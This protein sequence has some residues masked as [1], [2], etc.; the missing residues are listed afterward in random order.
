MVSW[1]WCF[2]LNLPIGGLVAILLF[3]I[4]IPEQMIKP[5]IEKAARTIIHELDLIGFALFSPAAIQ[6][7][8]A[9]SYGSNG[10]YAWNSATVIGLFGGAAGTFAVFLLWEHH[11]GAKA[12][13]PLNMIVNRK[14]WA[15]CLVM[16]GIYGTVNCTSYYLPI[17][18]QS[19]HNYSP[20]RSGISLLPVM[21]GQVVFSVV[22]GL[23]IQQLGYYMP[24][25]ICGGALGGISGGLLSTL[26][27]YSPTGEWIVYQLLSGVG[28]GIIFQVPVVAIQN[29][30]PPSETSIG[31]AVLV[32]S[33][34]LA[35][36]TIITIANVIFD[37]GLKSL[38]PQ[39]AP[40]V[41]KEAVIAAGATGFRS[42]VAKAD[43]PGVIQAYAKSCDYVFYVVTG[44]GVL[45]FLAAWGTGWVDIRQKKLGRRRDPT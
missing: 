20:I 14:V 17:Y 39:N 5:P 26:S 28:R 34:T 38:L 6:L 12:M 7:L 18:F 10:K 31:M 13:I 35:G 2:Y 36:A 43:I 9:L 45:M 42:V 11:Q 44:M 4:E 8:L 32:F 41:N 25:A 3:I 30:L 15:S 1:R 21:L 19:V 37:S 40:N 22:S 23:L 29:A 27:A 33:Q 24:F 16:M